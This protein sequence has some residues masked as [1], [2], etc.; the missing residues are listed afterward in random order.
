MGT[1]A[2]LPDADM[3]DALTEHEDHA[4]RRLA[5]LRVAQLGLDGALFL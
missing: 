5:R 1:G 2:T 4:I 3:I